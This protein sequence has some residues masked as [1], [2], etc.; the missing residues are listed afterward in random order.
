MTAF[1][2]GTPRTWTAGDIV[3]H[4]QLNTEVRDRLRSL[5]YLN[6]YGVGLALTEPKSVP[7]GETTPV[8]WDTATWQVGSMWSSDETITLPIDG[9]Y[10][11]QFAASWFFHASGTRRIGVR[12]NG[13]KL[14]RSS[15][16]T[17]TDT[18]HQAGL[19]FRDVFQL[20]A[21]D[22]LA[23]IA[24]QTCGQDLR[25]YIGNGPRSETR[26]SIRLLG[27]V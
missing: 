23:L 27:T 12:V 13:Q 19:N 9:F 11:V 5:R 6:D 2:N 21:G 3:R 20:S 17:V 14:W 26:A 16:Q 7:S 22:E 18:D 4:W 8:P 1:W 25:L 10:A 15:C 24:F